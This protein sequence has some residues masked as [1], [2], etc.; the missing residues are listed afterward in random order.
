MLNQYLSTSTYT[1]L[2]LRV[3]R[4]SQEGLV[5]QDIQEERYRLDS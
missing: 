3:M 1:F 2:A 4:A 5:S